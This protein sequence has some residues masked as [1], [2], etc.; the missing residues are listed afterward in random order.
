MK[1]EETSHV[2]PVPKPI[3]PILILC[4]IQNNRQNMDQS[5]GHPYWVWTMGPSTPTVWDPGQKW[6]HGC[7]YQQVVSVGE[8]RRRRCPTLQRN[9]GSVEENAAPGRTME[10]TR[11]VCDEKSRGTQTQLVAL[12]G[13]TTWWCNP[14]LA[15]K[16]QGL[17]HR[18]LYRPP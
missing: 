5:A 1:I 8:T 16:C 6:G 10:G 4:I 17:A 3:Y 11:R 9:P 18:P 14:Q 7:N 12:V 2:V 15:T 13:G